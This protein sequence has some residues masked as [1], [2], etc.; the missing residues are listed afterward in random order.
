ML[1][2]NAER[3]DETGLLL[4]N[5]ICNP[6]LLKTYQYLDATPSYSSTREAVPNI[7][8]VNKDYVT[9]KAYEDQDYSHLKNTCLL[10]DHLYILSLKYIL[11]GYIIERDNNNLTTYLSD[12][13][14]KFSVIDTSE[15]CKFE[16]GAV[17]L[18]LLHSTEVCHGR[19]IKLA[20]D[21]VGGFHLVPSGR[22][23]TMYKEKLY[24]KFGY[25]MVVI[26]DEWLCYPKDIYKNYKIEHDW[27]YT[28]HFFTNYHLLTIE[29]KIKFVK[30]KAKLVLGFCK[31]IQQGF[32]Y[33]EKRYCNV[34]SELLNDKSIN[35]KKCTD[36]IEKIDIVQN[37]IIEFTSSYV[38]DE[39][40][41]EI[42]DY[43]YIYDAAN[44]ID[45]LIEERARK[46]KNQMRKHVQKVRREKRA[47]RDTI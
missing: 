35:F 28:Y 42:K 18:V 40:V 43:T 13:V 11:F 20:Y 33:E 12:I 15:V 7:F 22:A 36:M 39:Y 47:S 32:V 5:Y 38:G 37:S 25:L 4:K 9:T 6:G 16:K 41:S 23:K 27:Q 45:S 26:E 19:L 14:D 30:Y 2:K 3:L 46:N 17:L 1:L 31:I 34:F 21:P 29:Q 8:L 24:W 10:N 44:N